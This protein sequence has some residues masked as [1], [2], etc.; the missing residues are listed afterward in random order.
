MTA[1]VLGYDDAGDGDALVLVH[2]FPFDRR[3]WDG[4]LSGLS[5]SR[6]VVAIDLR[7]RGKSSDLD[8]DG[9]T[10]ETA[11]QD[12]AATIDSLGADKVDIAGMSMGGYVVLAF[13]RLFPEKVRSLILIDTK[14]AEDAPEAKE[15]REKTAALVREKGTEELVVGL[16]P[17]LYGP[18]P[19]SELDERAKQMFLDTPSETA[20]ADALAMR[21]RPDSTPL[22][23]TITVPTL[24]LH[25]EMDQ[26]MP[27]EVGSQLAAAI[28]DAKFVPIPNG[29]HLAAMENP[30]AVNQ[31]IK[32]F[33]T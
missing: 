15:G 27:L 3:M 10:M 11:A 5:D 16:L 23:A 13:W 25:G 28:P 8:A 24:V 1:K 2:G 22:L 6:R 17:K 26:L 30:S 32:G 14:A 7:G 9:W 12:I 33:L 29:G 31:A 20:A 18:T 19:S 21:D 4:Q